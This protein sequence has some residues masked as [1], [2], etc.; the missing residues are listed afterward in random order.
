M[1]LFYLHIVGGELVTSVVRAKKFH[2]L[3]LVLCRKFTEKS[4]E[5][6]C[7]WEVATLFVHL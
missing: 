5:I 1:R 7:V 4:F 2:L 3:P 6:C